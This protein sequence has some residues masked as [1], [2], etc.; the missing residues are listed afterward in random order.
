[1]VNLL[2]SGVFMFV[3][4]IIPLSMYLSALWSMTVYVLL[5]PYQRGVGSIGAL[6]ESARLVRGFKLEII[7]VQIAFYAISQLSFW[8]GLISFGILSLILYAMMLW[9]QVGMYTKLV[10]LKG[11][12]NSPI[13][14]IFSDGLEAPWWR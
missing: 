1:M 10:E 13:P 3:W 11:T 4:I 9:M 5:D 2:L 8:L 12:S 14:I 6:R 7:I